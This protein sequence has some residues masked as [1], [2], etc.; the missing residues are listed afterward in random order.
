[1]EKTAEKYTKYEIARILGARALQI[2]MNAPMLLSISKDELE[3]LNYD[4]LKIAELEFNAKVLPIT[5]R[6]PMPQK[7]EEA[8]EEKEE[9]E[10]EVVG[11]EAKVEEAKVEEKVAA[12]VAAPEAEEEEVPETEGPEEI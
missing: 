4:P 8:E 3:E 5:V 9:E 10:I 12:E 6:R 2:S 1:M 11:E 7:E